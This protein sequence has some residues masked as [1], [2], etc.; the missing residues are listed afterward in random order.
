MLT[1]S[2]GQDAARC[3]YFV[4]FHAAQALIFERTEKVAKTHHGVRTEFLR[5][6]KDEVRGEPELRSFLAEAYGYK[7]K[8]DYFADD[9][10]VATV[11]TATAAL[12]TATRFLAHVL[13]LL[14]PMP[15]GEHPQPSRLP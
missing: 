7:S 12:E 10:L 6:T 3:A 14:G 2:L 8:A 1:V 11:E 9:G 13:A 4:C 5:L 15:D